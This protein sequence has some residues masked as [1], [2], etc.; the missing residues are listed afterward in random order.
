MIRDLLSAVGKSWRFA[1]LITATLF[2]LILTRTLRSQG[3]GSRRWIV[4]WHAYMGLERDALEKLTRRFNEGN[5]GTGV[6]L[7]MV[8]FD[9]LPQKITN[10]VPRGHGPD[11][12]IF[13]HDRMGDWTSKGMLEPLGFFLSTG[14]VKRFI[15]KTL[16]A[17]ILRGALYG[18]PLTYKSVA[19]YHNRS[20]VP[21]PPATTDELL[22]MGRRLTRRSEGRFGLVYEAAFTYYHAPWLFGFGG[23]FLDLD[24]CPPR[25]AIR[26]EE[27]Y[28]AL[29]FARKLAG[30]GGIVP[31][32]V[33][34]QL[35]TSLFKEGRAAMA[36]S[37]PW[38]LS[39]LGSFPRGRTPFGIAEL[40]VVSRTGRKAS[41]LLSVEGIFMSSQCRDKERAFRF[42]R[43]L[44]SDASSRFR[45]RH[46]RQL[47]ANVSVDGA[48]H[49]TDPLL[50][51]FKRQ[52]RSA[53]LT[54]ATPMMR[55]LWQP[56]DKALNAVIARG[57]DP[58]A[59]LKEVDWEVGKTLGACLVKRRT[60]TDQ[61]ASR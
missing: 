40:P 55:I 2:L 16:S 1:A 30:P 10:A 49:E 23:R 32:E 21:R 46:A 61:G 33:T 12:F 41:P 56:Y 43:F 5:P 36:I 57:V 31:P 22:D 14:E 17:F 44:T 35:T 19:L 29:R 6:R 9:N 15:P 25:L 28:E 27:A 11:L 52:M 4:V 53:I 20:L 59:A 34:A 60:C 58:K 7:L 38:L 48:L 3:S 39:G 13:A 18:L 37:G 54:P 8:S 47:P 50:V 42:A 45:L 26:S 24:R 51:A